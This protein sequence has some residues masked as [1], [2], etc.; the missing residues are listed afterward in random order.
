MLRGNRE[1]TMAQKSPGRKGTRRGKRTEDDA[2]AAGPRDAIIAAM[3]ALAA[4]E[5]WR[6]LTLSAIAREAG[7]SLADLREHYA[8]KA[9]ILADFMRRTDQDV[10]RRL[11]REELAESTHDRLFD[12]VMMRLEALR[13]HK[14]A[15]RNIVRELPETPADWA[16][17]TCSGFIAQRWMLAGAGLETPGSRGIARVAGLGLVYGRILRTWLREDDPGMPRTMAQ[18]DRLLRRG[19]TTLRRLETPIALCSA[20]FGFAR[21]VTGEARKARARRRPRA[22]G[23]SSEEAARA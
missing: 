11:E 23:G 1:R 9:E 2:K 18:L 8:T 14:A 19:E 16:A 7:L 12:V 13:P 17:L 22:A 3:L 10:L 4:D 21:T 6:G 15:L 20:L 5:G